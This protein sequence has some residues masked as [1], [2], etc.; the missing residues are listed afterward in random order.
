MVPKNS[1]E[2]KITLKIKSTSSPTDFQVKT[3]LDESISELGE[4]I[5]S[6]LNKVGKNIRLISSGK[7]LE[8]SNSK[9]RDFPLLQD[10][11][12]VH[13]VVSERINRQSSSTSNLSSPHLPVDPSSLRGLDLLVGEG[14]STHEVAAIR[15]AFQPQIQEFSGTIARRDGEDAVTYV[16]RVEELW[17]AAQPAQSEF[18][19][20]LPAHVSLSTRSGPGNPGG[21]YSRNSGASEPLLDPS[22]GF[23]RAEHNPMFRSDSMHGELEEVAEGSWTDFV[24]GFML[25]SMLGFILVFCV[26]DRNVPYRQKAGILCGVTLHMLMT[27]LQQ[28]GLNQRLERGESHG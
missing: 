18:L 20:N 12:Y 15:S 21:T 10:G 11:S 24:W 3:N 17:M 6:D 16:S 25:G 19:L 23:T 14:M 22:I 13:A 1:T 4:K 9:L 8:P 26:W 2:N 27:Y 28:K 7:L 5:L